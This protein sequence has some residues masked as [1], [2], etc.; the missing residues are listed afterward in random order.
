MSEVDEATVSHAAPALSLR[1]P[2]DAGG[3]RSRWNKINRN[4]ILGLCLVCAIIL[5]AWIGPYFAGYD[6]I[7]QDLTQAMQQPSGAHLAWH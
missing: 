1:V 5:V 2:P 4:L 3:E 7:A 6:P